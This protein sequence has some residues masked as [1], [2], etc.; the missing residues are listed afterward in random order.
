MQEPSRA[1]KRALLIGVRG[2]PSIPPEFGEPLAGCHNDVQ[3]MWETL[4]GW[5]FHPSRI[6]VLVDVWPGCGCRF[7]REAGSQGSSETQPAKLAG[8]EPTR[9]GILQAVARL[10]D[11]TGPEDVVVIYYSGHGSEYSGRGLLAGR[12]FQTLVPHDSGRG[13]AENRDIADREIEGWIR[14]FGARTPYLTLIFD[15]CHSGGLGDLR[16]APDAR[17]RRVRE[18]VRPAEEAFS[19]GVLECLRAPEPAAAE[20]ADR[21]GSGWLRGSGRSAIV[22]SASAAKELSSETVA[23]GKK[24]GLFTT[25]LTRALDEARAEGRAVGGSRWGEI[26]AAVAEAVSREN[27]SQHPRR[28]GDGPIFDRGEI[29]LSDVFPPDVVELEKL[30]VIIGLDYQA[31]EGAPPPGSFSPLKTPTRDARELARVLEVAQGYEVVGTSAKRPGPLLDERATRRNI[32]R[33]IDRLIRVKARSKRETAVLIYFAGH[34]VTHTRDDGEVVGYLVPWGAEADDPDTWLPM[35]DLR[36]HLVDGIADA[37]RLAALDLEKPLSRLV[38]RHLM[39]V[40]DCCFGGALSFDFFRGGD[41]PERPVYYSEYRRFVEGSAWQMLS[42]ASYNQQAMDRNPR[43]PEQQHSP[44]AEALIEGLTTDRADVVAD[45]GRGDHIVTATELHQHIDRRL[46]ELGVDVQ[47]PGLVALRPVDGQYIFRVPGYRPSPWPD[48]SLDPAANPWLGDRSYGSREGEEGLFC[49]RELATLELL[50]LF[51]GPEL[52]EPAES[53]A[54]GPQ[55]VLVVCGES[56]SGTSSLVRAGLLPILENPVR[57]RR[58]LLSFARRRGL[59]RFLLTREDLR[60]VRSWAEEEA[61]A[62]PEEL[63]STEEGVHERV[64]KRAREWAA[65][66][67]RRVLDSSAKDGRSELQMQSLGMPS[68]GFG[69]EADPAGDW[70]VRVGLSGLMGSASSLVEHLRLWLATGALSDFF[71]VSDRGLRHLVGRWEVVESAEP[72]EPGTRRVLW[73]LDDSEQRATTLG[74]E[75]WEAVCAGGENRIVTTAGPDRHGGSTD[76]TVLA[77]EVPRQVFSPP[78]P[79]REELREMIDA[80]AAARVIFFEPPELAASLVEQVVATPTPIPLLSLALT[81]MYEGAWERRRDSDRQLTAADLGVATVAALV[82]ERAERAFCRLA[83]DGER[84]RWLR[85]LF[86][87]AVVVGDGEARPRAVAWR[88]LGLADPSGQRALHDEILPVLARERVLVLGAE[89]IRL[90]CQ[91]LLGAWPRLRRWVAAAGRIGLDPL[92]AWRRAR[93]WEAS[94][95]DPG[96]LWRH[97]ALTERLADRPELNRLEKAFLVASDLSRRL[98]R[99]RILAA[100]AVAGFHRDWSRHGAWAA[101]AAEETIRIREGVSRRLGETWLRAGSEASREEVAAVR[102]AEAFLH[103]ARDASREVSEQALQTLLGATPFSIPLRIPAELEGIEGLAFDGES[104]LRVRSGGRVWAWSLESPTAP[105]A[106]RSGA[107]APAAGEGQVQPRRRWIGRDQQLPP[108]RGPGGARAQCG[109]DRSIRYLPPRKG[110]PPLP[111]PPWA[112]GPLALMGHRNVPRFL[113][114]SPEGRWLASA[115]LGGERGNGEV[116]LWPVGSDTGLPA[117]PRVELGTTLEAALPEVAEQRP[118]GVVS[119]LDR[120]PAEWSVGEE[121]WQIRR[122]AWDG[123][124]FDL[125]RIETGESWTQELKPDARPGRKLPQRLLPPPPSRPPVPVGFLPIDEGGLRE[126]VSSP[127]GLWLAAVSESGVAAVWSLPELELIWSTA[128][129]WRVAFLSFSAGGHWLAAVGRD[130]AARLWS[131]PAFEPAWSRHAEGAEAI[132]HL[133]FPPDPEGAIRLA[134]ARESGQPLL[135]HR[136][137]S[138]SEPGEGAGGQ[139]AAMAFGPDGRRLALGDLDGSVRLWHIDPS[140]ATFGRGRGSGPLVL[141]GNDGVGTAVRDLAFSADSRIL[142]VERQTVFEPGARQVDFYRLDLEELALL[143]RGHAGL[144]DSRVEPPREIAGRTESRPTTPL[145]AADAPRRYLELLGL[146]D[147]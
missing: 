30:A 95:F 120:L 134:V 130:G 23:G 81:R 48:P 146:V 12:R 72:P 45:G 139:V 39:L 66:T 84:R 42:S 109:Y 5:G 100:R 129:D 38:S 116:R 92:G 127:D 115:A 125:T 68:F 50:D 43:D 94:R 126:I 82:A 128:G 44:F 79:T 105:A 88:E 123:S 140:A 15:C 55:P 117:Q 136:N 80:P 3:R 99:V 77:E 10:R 110:G 70:A 90:S 4:E 111:P 8:G 57:Q 97:D 34:G 118:G 31:K 102:A 133:V 112:R 74:R 47:T 71:T 2:Y 33:V 76:S 137:G 28:E 41:G 119:H 60:E 22:L 65:R 89:G 11:D 135:L 108:V 141:G 113:A 85:Q 49:G 106:E 27:L 143:A 58:R 114:F 51:L 132:R 61:I 19:P 13:R 52:G 18:D 87:R 144:A 103:E 78:R 83:T 6:R 9:E 7:C 26:F 29:D 17:G 69:G 142:G 91:E 64:A 36:D 124:S 67:G 16:G 32:H 21:G 121:R 131:L 73:L 75:A 59:S 63:L 54:A 53:D 104:H 24:Q 62:S 122:L 101:L 25:H 145:D 147:S 37:E 35:K 107:E 40:L 96:K 20:G 1:M 14:A 138:E 98:D 56:G 86:L 46:G 93:E